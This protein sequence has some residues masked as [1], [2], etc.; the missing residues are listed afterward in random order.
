MPLGE[1]FVILALI[2]GMLIGTISAIIGIGGGIL[3]IPASIFIFGFSLKEAIVI[4]LFSMTG[5]NISASIR[6]MKMKLVNY[7]LATIYNIWD[8]PGVLVGAWIT[9]IITHN[10][11]SGICGGIIIILSIMLFRK[12]NQHKLEENP[13]S[14]MNGE[15][16]GKINSE[17]KNKTKLGVNNLVIASFSSFS[18]GFISGLGGVGGGTSD[19]TTMILLGIDP[20]EA[21]ATS[22]FAMV[23]TSVFGVIVHILFGTYNGSFLWPLMMTL[24]GVIGAQVGIYLSTQV[25]SKIVRKILAVFASYTG[26]LLI[27]LMFNIGWVN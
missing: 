26:I 5:L 4:S 10:A 14:Q 21:A 22:Q 18:G 2:L 23:F 8:L 9:S 25:Q 12:N 24:G 1:E 20:K 7:R 3:F 11:L 6:Y 15:N 17:L 27:L 19:T 13:G 16:I